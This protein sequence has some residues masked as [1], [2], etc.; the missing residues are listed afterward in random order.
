MN[1][2]TLTLNN[3]LAYKAEDYKE[4]EDTH[5][6]SFNHSLVQ[7]N[8]AYLV[9]KDSDYSALI[10]LSLDVSSL[11][12]IK[13]SDIKSESYANSNQVLASSDG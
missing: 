8:L 5:I 7:G 6:G 9:R 3:E 12:K 10:E 11:D 1:A 4:E 13:F 2:P